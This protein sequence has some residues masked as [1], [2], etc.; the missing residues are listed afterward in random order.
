MVRTSCVL[1]LTAVLGLSFYKL[2]TVAAQVFPQGNVAYGTFG[3]RTL[4]QPLVPR[5]GTFGGGVQT[6]PGGNFLYLG[7]ADGSAMFATPWRHIDPDV[8]LPVLVASPAEQPAPN[9]VVAP[10]SPAPQFSAAQPSINPDFVAGLL[11]ET[12]GGEGTGASEQAP[13]VGLP[14]I[15]KVT[16]PQSGTRAA[17]ASPRV[18]QPYI[19]S[20][21][22][23]DRLT[24]IARSKGML[25]SQGIDVYL[26]NNI[27]RLQGA[28]RTPGDGILLA[29]IL[30]L[31]PG[32]RQID[33]RLVV[34]GPGTP[35]SK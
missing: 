35:S 7:R 20:P 34:E 2:P 28:V 23:S 15:P 21:E 19:R 10:Q 24:R 25:S 17:A 22:L 5:P 8:L 29:S 12:S 1:A 30:G 26:S 16:A 4:G 6:G 33:N 27:A 32:V 13:G 3:S 11:S 9:A 31:E 18:A 14:A